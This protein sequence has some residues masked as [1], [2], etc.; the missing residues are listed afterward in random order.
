MSLGL[1][2]PQAPL[3][4]LSGWAE[5]GAIAAPKL[6]RRI[7]E[8]IVVAARR[9]KQSKAVS[10][11]ASA[12]IGQAGFSLV[13]ALVAS[14]LLM[15]AVSQS[16]NIFGVTMNA[17]G[18]SRIRD[19]LNAAIHADLESV[20]NEVST[21]KLDTSI[22]GMTAY[23]L[24]GHEEA[25]K[26]NTLATELL[27]EKRESSKLPATLSSISLGN[28]SIPPQGS[29]VSRTIN[30]FSRTDS[31]S[32]DGNLIEV[33]YN[34]NSGS[35]VAIERRAVISIPAQGWCVYD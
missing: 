13:E 32:G 7:Q 14:F 2:S 27:D 34:T 11:K 24:S 33:S 4:H 26:T 9:H 19:G 15:L 1:A 30:V 28:S 20:R 25:C 35:V 18:A 3:R 23:N 17:L 21:W 29:S 5:L 16:L 8:V 22:D 10:S 6:K 31:G 12:P